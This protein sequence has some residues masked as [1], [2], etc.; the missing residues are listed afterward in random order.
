MNMPT[1]FDIELT[2]EEQAW[3]DRVLEHE[4]G[5]IQIAELCDHGHANEC[6]EGCEIR[7]YWPEEFFARH[8]LLNVYYYTLGITDESTKP[9]QER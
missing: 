9:F 4:D 7:E 8:G 2:H 6:E 3:L 5:Q 1:D